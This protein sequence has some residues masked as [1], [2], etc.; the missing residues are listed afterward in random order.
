MDDLNQIK[1]VL[2]KK[3]K[4]VNGWRNNLTKVAV[5]LAN[6]V[7]ILHNQIFIHWNR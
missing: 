4:Q 2:V 6:G 1:V 3:R 7:P 5:L